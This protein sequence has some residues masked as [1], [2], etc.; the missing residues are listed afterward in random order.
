MQGWR[1]M[2]AADLPDVV[3]IGDIVHAEFPES[4][5][6]F[7]E[8]LALFPDGC[9]KTLDGYAIAHPVRTG[10]PPPLDT[11]L[12]TLDPAADALHVHDVALLPSRRGHGLGAAAM[13]HFIAV[14]QAHGLARLSLVSV[15]GTRTYWS[16]FGFVQMPKAGL[17][18]YG[19][20]AAYMERGL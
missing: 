12:G 18:S 17:E 11:M 5:A 14:A 9:L 10:Y 4:P 1:Q 8:R 13:A 16:R 2:A 7:A 19:P 20:E 15:Y 3:R 6:L